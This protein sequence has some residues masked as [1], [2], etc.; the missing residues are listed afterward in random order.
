[1]GSAWGGTT[2]KM[3]N[4]SAAVTKV[5]S[6]SKEKN[7]HIYTPGH[8]VNRDIKDILMEGSIHLRSKGLS[9]FSRAYKAWVDN[10]AALPDEDDDFET[11][12][13]GNTVE[14][15]VHSE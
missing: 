6:K 10:S 9:T 15:Q 5:M 4:N 7:L 3:P 2:H 8:K 1:M 14:L 11:L 13:V 12:V